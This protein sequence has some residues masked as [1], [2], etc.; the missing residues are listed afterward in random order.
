MSAAETRYS[1]VSRRMWRDEKFRALSAPKP[2][3]RYLWL[4][5]LTGT[6]CTAIPG[7]F[8]IGEAALAEELGWPVAATRSA[9]EEIERGGMARVDRV[10]R[11]VWLPNA[12]AHNPPA[13][14]NVVVGWRTPWSELPT[15]DLLT[16][17]RESFR[18]VLAEMGPEFARSFAIALGEEKPRPSPNPSGGR[19]PKALVDP[20]AKGEP[21][22]SPSQ[23][24]EQEQEQEQENSDPSAIGSDAPPAGKGAAPTKRK[25]TSSVSESPLPF[26]IAKALATIT[27]ASNGRFASPRDGEFHRKHLRPLTALIRAIPDL[28]A[29]ERVG[30][31]IGSGAIRRPDLS[32]AW[33]LGSDA[34]AL[35]RQWEETQGNPMVSGVFDVPTGDPAA[36]EREAK[37]A[38]WQR[39]YDAIQAAK[40]AEVAARAAS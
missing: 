12:L 14:P 15:C 36:L 34:F 23:D 39:K 16:E 25:A 8:S 17:A 19:R 18:R 9:L 38:E 37:L 27:A 29:W 22:P 2:C 1:R 20:L 32:V 5:L 3:A 24:Q 4:F 28:G 6:H 11:L 26:T 35:S 40:A 10:A 7:L 30:R 13:S 31:W 33:L 21:K